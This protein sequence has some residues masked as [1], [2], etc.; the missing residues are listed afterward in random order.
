[1]R[2]KKEYECPYCGKTH[3]LATR[4]REEVPCE[5]AKNVGAVVWEEGRGANKI[6]H[7]RAGEHAG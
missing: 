2:K 7:V 1:M 6:L 4:A 3:V 5:P